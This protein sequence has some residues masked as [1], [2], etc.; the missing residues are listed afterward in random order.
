M[1]RNAEQQ[2]RT[3]FSIAFARINSSST[4]QGD[5]RGESLRSAAAPVA[6]GV[7]GL[8]APEGLE[9][10]QTA[11]SLMAR[12]AT[13]L[14]EVACWQFIGGGVGGVVALLFFLI[15][16]AMN[17]MEPK[18]KPP[19]KVAPVFVPSGCSTWDDSNAACTELKT[20]IDN[21]LTPATR[22]LLLAK[23]CDLDVSPV[24]SELGFYWQARCRTVYNGKNCAAEADRPACEQEL[25]VMEASCAFLGLAADP[26]SLTPNDVDTPEQCLDYLKANTVSQ[27]EADRCA[28]S[29]SMAWETLYFMTGGDYVTNNRCGAVTFAA[30]VRKGTDVPTCQ[31]GA[32]YNAAPDNTGSSDSSLC[33]AER[34]CDTGLLSEMIGAIEQGKPEVPDAND[35]YET[36]TSDATSKVTTATCNTGWE[37]E[38]GTAG[39]FCSHVPYTDSAGYPIDATG[40]RIADISDSIGT[41][42]GG[43][44]CKRRTCPDQCG[45]ALGDFITGDAL[46]TSPRPPP[47]GLTDTCCSGVYGDLCDIACERGYRSRK[48]PNTENPLKHECAVDG[49]DTQ[50]APQ[51]TGA[52]CD[53]MQCYVQDLA[54]IAGSA[55]NVDGVA[56]AAG[57]V[58]ISWDWT[59]S[60]NSVTCKAGYMRVGDLACQPS[61]LFQGGGCSDRAAAAVLAPSI[62]QATTSSNLADKD[63]AFDNDPSTYWYS[64]V[65]S[66]ASTEDPVWLMVELES[67][68][69]PLGFSIQLAKSTQA[70]IT[71]YDFE[72]KAKA[73]ATD[74]EWQSFGMDATATSGAINQVDIV[75]TPPCNDVSIDPIGCA[76]P[77]AEIPCPIDPARGEVCNSILAQQPNGCN[78]PIVS[79]GV[80]C[81]PTEFP[82]RAINSGE[83]KV[84]MLEITDELVEGRTDNQ[85]YGNIIVEDIALMTAGQIKKEITN[86]LVTFTPETQT[87][88]GALGDCTLNNGVMVDGTTYQTTTMPD[89]VAAVAADPTVDYM[90]FNEQ[91]NGQGTCFGLAAGDLSRAAA[92]AIVSAGPFNGALCWEVSR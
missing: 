31:D 77:G 11:P 15:L 55:P 50:A 53:P 92:P 40:A 56:Q 1:Y 35:N 80:M 32:S 79:S 30:V 85:R 5:Q 6:Q 10:L 52:G 37:A 65:Q 14:T 38:A 62:T 20:S 9:G 24:V 51:W 23:P 81:G 2:Y 64:T 78:F 67:S 21:K 57:V 29:P 76:D 91:A 60:G 54:N 48:D 33:T 41:W 87:C 36:W 27:G 26:M 16:G 22:D 90:Q 63:F 46:R 86:G 4:S 3:G 43:L 12:A 28:T 47:E 44:Q 59:Y 69:V 39:Y 13:G 89:C 71:P 49:T 84:F 7:V 45:S 68:I 17:G 42:V 74:A 66:A 18:P 25:A 34:D 61:L 70:S 88:C 82:I 58:G 73:D 83:Y 19:E 72:L 8:A 75:W